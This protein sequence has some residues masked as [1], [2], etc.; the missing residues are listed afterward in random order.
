MAARRVA[1]ILS[2]CGFL[3]GA[4]I[5]EAVLSLLAL[6]RHGADVRCFAPDV[7]QRRVMNH[8]TKEVAHETRNVLVEAARITRGKIED[9]RRA[10]AGS[11]DAAFLPG[12][13]GAA[14]NLS[15]YGLGQDPFHIEAGTKAFLEEMI[16]AGK[17]VGA[18]CIAP[19]IVAKLLRDAG[20]TR[21]PHFTVG[22][23]PNADGDRT[24]ALTGG[25][26]V[27]CAVTECVVDEKNRFVSSPA[28]MCAPTLAELDRGIDKAVAATLALCG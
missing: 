4:E 7:A 6:S 10:H 1:V 20:V 14:L 12:G 19:P 3:D 23:E 21:S 16:S 9:V 11:F 8:L 17:P 26:H 5:H 27:A 2:G 22:S 15:D 18:L 13:F 25:V 24:A 28:Y